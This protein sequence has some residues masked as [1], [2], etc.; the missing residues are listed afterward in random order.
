MHQQTVF[1]SVLHRN[2]KA[3]HGLFKLLF[4]H[5]L[6]QIIVGLHLERLKHHLF[7]YRDKDQESLELKSPQLPCRFY[8]V[9]TLHLDIQK[10][11]VDLPV[12][13]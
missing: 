2:V 10:Q 9:H 13:A 7:Q 8:A 3:L 4:L 1:A 5:R 6:D 11:D 12:V